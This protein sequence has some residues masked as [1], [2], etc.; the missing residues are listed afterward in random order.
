MVVDICGAYVNVNQILPWRCFPPHW[1]INTFLQRDFGLSILLWRGCL[2]GRLL[3]SNCWVQR[4]FRIVWIEQNILFQL[5]NRMQFPFLLNIW[6]K[7][8][9]I[10]LF[11]CRVTMSV[12]H[13]LLLVLLLLCLLQSLLLAHQHDRDSD[14]LPCF[15]FVITVTVQLLLM[16]LLVGSWY[17]CL[18]LEKFS[19][20]CWNHEICACL[21]LVIAIR[22]SESL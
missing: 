7:L 18:I 2:L 21:I 11:K 14:C 4:L 1:S 16:L 22:P 9:I 17:N 8:V 3:L 20:F 6:L 5:F 15:I 10:L 12:P 13:L 19:G